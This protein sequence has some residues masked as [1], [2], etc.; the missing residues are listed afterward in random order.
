MSRER[1][2]LTE[3]R[4]ALVV[5][6]PEAA[7][8]VDGWRERTSPAKPS[9]GVP[10]H[11][12]VLFPFVPAAEVDDELI[13]KLGEL[14]AALPSFASS[15]ANAATSQGCCTSHPSRPSRSSR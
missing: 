14:F 11:V 7:A 2:G 9:N 15:S 12:T 4:T 8:A 1:S 3:P 5:E 13:R 10:S 6:V